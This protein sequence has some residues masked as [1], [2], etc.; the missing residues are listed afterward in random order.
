MGRLITL[1][2]ACDRATL[3]LPINSGTS[4]ELKHASESLSSCGPLPSYD[5]LSGRGKIVQRD[6]KREVGDR[7]CCC[8]QRTIHYLAIVRGVCV[9]KIARYFMEASG[10]AG[11]RL[12]ESQR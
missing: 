4:P 10:K 8:Q 7:L 5:T 9:I 6:G 3:S 2:V 12:K 1:C 11:S